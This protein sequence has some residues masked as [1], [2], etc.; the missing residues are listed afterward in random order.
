MDPRI[1]EILPALIEHYD[2]PFAD[3]SA[4]PTLCLARMTRRH[5]TVALSGD[6]AD[7]IFGGYRRYYYGILEDKI[8]DKF[9]DRF[10]RPVFAFAGRHYPKFDYLPQVF[11]AK[12]L[13][14]N[15]ARTLGDAYFNSISTFR[16]GD[17][18]AILSP[19][20]RRALRDYSPRQ[21]FC[22]R[23]DSVK[24]LAP[25]EQMQAVDF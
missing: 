2:E 10:R 6:G 23:F 19:E 20:L 21:D 17:L 1:H 9:P 13:L 25:L 22:A 24:H 3:S 15:L 7:E 12:A 16:D 8:R 14:S 11:R 5:V 18:L 4:V